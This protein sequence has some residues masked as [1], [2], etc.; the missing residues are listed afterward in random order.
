MHRTDLMIDIE[1]LDTRP[2]A[3]VL[4]IGAVVFNRKDPTVPF[5]E[6]ELTFG[7]KD[8]RASQ[9]ERG[10][11]IDKSTVAWWKQQSPAAQQVLREKNVDGVFQALELLEGFIKSQP[12]EMMVWGNGATFDCVITGSLF[13]SY[14]MERPWKYWN[15]RCFRTMKGEHGHII[16]PIHMEGTSHRAV[17]DAVYQARVLTAI[18]TELQ[19]SNLKSYKE[20]RNVRQR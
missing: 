5:E 16:D 8:C 13:E 11:T 1:T 4:S 17:D 3:V 20:K 7:T 18:Y 19:K 6:L 14:G 10:R 15:E 12:V 2:T 9:V